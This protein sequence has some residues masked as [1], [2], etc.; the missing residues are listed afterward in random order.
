MSDTA[1][2]WMNWSVQVA[3]AL[4]TI[5]AV[6][7]ALFGQVL[8]AKSF[9]PQLVLTLPRPHGEPER[10]RLTSKEF[11]DGREEEARFYRL[12][13]SNRRRWSPANQV[14]VVLLGVET[15]TADG[16][17]VPTWIGDVPL[18]WT[19]QQVFPALR[20][21]GSDAHVD[22][23][24]VVKDKWLQLHPLIVPFGLEVL[25][26]HGTTWRLWV[27][28]KSNECES[29]V[30]RVTIAWDGEWHHDAIEMR[31]HLRITAEEIME[32][33]RT[34]H[35]HQGSPRLT[36]KKRPRRGGP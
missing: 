3:A 8:R 23:C 17:F 31:H 1:Q 18:A 22:L 28:A 29:R 9:P 26:R 7:V 6:L 14:Q 25:S 24:S 15:P 4:G 32:E 35:E 13:V 2:F 34:V 16:Q 10:V 5:G 11:P 19:H 21:I 20:T 27:Q 30:H 36:L 12:C 33:H